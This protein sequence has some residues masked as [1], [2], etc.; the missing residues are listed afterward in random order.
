MSNV[1]LSDMHTID[2][3]SFVRFNIGYNS[4][5]VCAENIYIDYEAVSSSSYK[6]DNCTNK[7]ERFLKIEADGKSYRI[8]RKK[9]KGYSIDYNWNSYMDYNMYCVD[10]EMYSSKTIYI[11]VGG[12]DY[13]QSESKRIIE[14]LD[15]N[16]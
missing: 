15:D 6:H 7:K 16:V 13:G 1:G 12:G 11:K 2:K 9:M 4:K 3:N 14:Y 5:G 8:Q 10:I